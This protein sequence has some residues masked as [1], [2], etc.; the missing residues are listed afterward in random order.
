[1]NNLIYSSVC[2]LFFTPLL[3][4]ALTSLRISLDSCSTPGSLGFLFVSSQNS[5]GKSLWNCI[6]LILHTC[7]VWHSTWSGEHPY[8]AYFC[9][10]KFMATLSGISRV[11]LI[12]W[13][14][15]S[16]QLLSPLISSILAESRE[17][18]CQKSTPSIRSTQLSGSVTILL[19]SLF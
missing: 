11:P 5:P 13:K 12:S 18:R 17:S 6:S 14:T 9:F 1:M 7:P 10:L 2:S 4:C 19:G 16:Y 8:H 15:I 3:T